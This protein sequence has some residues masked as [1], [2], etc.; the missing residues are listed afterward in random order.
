MGA[1]SVNSFYGW[2]GYA[3]TPSNLDP[4]PDECN[5]E[6]AAGG[7]WVPSIFL[8]KNGRLFEHGTD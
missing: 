8:K 7:G 5:W 1:V 6:S 3:H 2:I 4:S